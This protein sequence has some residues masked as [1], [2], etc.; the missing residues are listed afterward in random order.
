MK[1][2]WLEKFRHWLDDTEASFE[3]NPKPKPFS[4]AEHLFVT[5]AREIE[6]AMRHEA[7]T[8]YGEPTYIPR[9]YLVFPSA[10][11][12]KDWHGEK[13]RG[14][15]RGLYN[16][17]RERAL[18]LVGK[19]HLQADTITLELRVD[20][21]LAK[22][23]VS[24]QAIWDEVEKTTVLSKKGKSSL[25]HE[26]TGDEVLD[27]DD[28]PTVVLQF[29]LLL[30]R[31][32]ASE[33]R[34]QFASTVTL[35]RGKDCDLHLSEDT[36]ISRLHAT[37]TKNKD[38]TFTLHAHGRNPIKLSDGDELTAGQEVQL[39]RSDSFKIG[40]YELTIK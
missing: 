28:A 27:P 20:A 2:I 7:F 11:D 21:T 33:P 19:Q 35:G 9:H 24:V 34:P 10:A 31:G 36:S 6:A 14:M 13:R 5:I 17:I 18:E 1:P 38:K 29:T 16:A 25:D 26:D 32:S 22:G 3:V 39:K 40:E 12:D 23:Q 8:P 4:Q 37:L 15:E 30:K